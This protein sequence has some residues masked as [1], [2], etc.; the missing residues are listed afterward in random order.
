MVGSEADAL[1]R[2]RVTFGCVTADEAV[3]ALRHRVTRGGAFLAMPHRFPVGSSLTVEHAIADGT[4]V[5]TVACRVSAVV[6]GPESALCVTHVGFG[7]EASR[8]FVNR[9]RPGL[10]W[11]AGTVN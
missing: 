2:I 6:S 4:V 8:S 3:T 5:A 1:P 11:I 7:D 9:L 10:P